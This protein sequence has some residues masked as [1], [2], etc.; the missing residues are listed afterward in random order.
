MLIG[1]LNGLLALAIL[2]AFGP[3][4]LPLL[5]L[6]AALA[7]IY[8]IALLFAAFFPGTA[9]CDPEFETE[10]PRLLGFH[11]QQLVSLILCVL[12]VV[13]VVFAAA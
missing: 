3:L 9:W 12:L 1:I 10:T 8:W 2:F 11:P 4:T 13:A 5:V 6:S 7:S